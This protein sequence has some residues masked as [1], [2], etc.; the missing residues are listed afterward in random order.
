M[1][2]AGNQSPGPREKSP[3]AAKVRALMT[4]FVVSLIVFFI[5]LLAGRAIAGNKA[6]ER[7]RQVTSALARAWQEGF[8]PR[9]R[10]LPRN[11][12]PDGT[13]GSNTA[14]LP[15]GGEEHPPVG[16][17]AAGSAG[18]APPGP[19]PGTSLD[20]T[21]HAWCPIL[22]H[23]RA[24]LRKNWFPRNHPHRCHVS[25]LTRRSGRCA[26][27]TSRSM[28]PRCSWSLRHPCSFPLP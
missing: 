15:A 11:P 16:P 21:R 17:A 14:P 9:G 23:R 8:A 12:R 22:P 2:Y 13:S 7:G 20:M 5:G 4:T 24:C 18:S 19:A 6:K 10:P 28:S 1:V 26:T 3:S 25:R 27:S